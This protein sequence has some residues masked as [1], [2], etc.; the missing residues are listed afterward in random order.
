MAFTDIRFDLVSRLP[1]GVQPYALLMRLDRPIGWW[2]LLLPGWWAITLAGGGLNGL[3][4]WDWYLLV[5]FFFGAIIMRGAGCIIND[6]WDRNIDAQVE[7]TRNRPL[8]SGEVKP[9]QAGLLLFI[10]CFLGLLILVQTSAMAF[11]LGMASMIF[12]VAYPYMKRITWWPQAFLGVTFNFGVLIGWAAVTNQLSVVAILMYL[13]AF[14]WTLGYDTIYA[15]QDKDDD[16]M[17]GIK[18]TALLFGERSK[19]WVAIFYAAA[20]TLLAAT[21][22]ISTK[23]ILSQGLIL[24]PGIHM[25]L[26]ILLWRPDDKASSLRWFKSNRDCGLLFLLTYLVAGL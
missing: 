15:H 21:I 17:V 9:W 26:Q 25:L 20:W 18:S 8:A 23:S 14:F 10:L 4:G 6:L 7:R 1:L 24:L 13:G 11:W 22:F 2:L 3:R 16:Q 19:K 12:V 5:L